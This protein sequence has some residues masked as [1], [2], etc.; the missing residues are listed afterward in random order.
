MTASAQARSA[1]RTAE[2]EGISQR[3]LIVMLYRGAERFLLTARAGMANAQIEAAHDNCLKAKA[4]FTELISTLNE[5][6]GGAF[7]VRL[8]ALYAFFIV[9]I[10]EANLL[11]D[12]T[13]IDEILP[14]VAEIRSGWEQVPDEF[15]NTSSLPD[16]GRRGMV[17][18]RT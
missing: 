11:K 2:V 16:Q 14:M 12:P 9:R 1:Y 10:S 13:K 3:D 15:A 17:D 18:I 6:A 5:E 4:I 8:R 7:A